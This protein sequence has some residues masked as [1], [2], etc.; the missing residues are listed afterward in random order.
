MTIGPDGISTITTSDDVQAAFIVALTGTTGAGANVFAP[1][2]WPTPLG[3]LP[4]LMLQA[5]K[6]HK[7][8]LGPNAPAYDVSTTIRVIGRLTGKAIADGAAAGVLLTALGVLQRQ[9]EAAV[10]NNYELY[11]IISEIESVDTENAVKSEG[12]QPIGEVT[13]DFVCKFYQ[14]PEAFAQPTLTPIAELA[15][16]GDLVNVF[17]P[18]GTYTKPFNYPVAPAPRTA[19]PDG[20]VEAGAIVA[21]EP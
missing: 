1:R 10:I 12:N 21:L 9:I 19:G 15:V 2:D 7:G 4:M 11:R 6:E 18:N 20:R 5:P 13:M 8:S 16:Y 14:G 17:D 3:D